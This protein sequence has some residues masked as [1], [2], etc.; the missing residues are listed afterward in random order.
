MIVH[1]LFPVTQILYFIAFPRCDWLISEDEFRDHNVR[2][3]DIPDPCMASATG[4][5]SA[6]RS[7]TLSPVEAARTALA[8]AEKIN[9]DLNAFT[10]LDHDGA[11]SAA[12]ESAKRWRDGTPLSAIDGVPT[13]AKD[14]VLCGLDIRYG[15][16]GTDEVSDQCDAPA[17]FLTRMPERRSAS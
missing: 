11:H 5:T 8:R 4:L 14:I 6:F 2:S 12:E 7:G 9:P 10:L 13:T 1:F 16:A 3:D 17:A 15:S